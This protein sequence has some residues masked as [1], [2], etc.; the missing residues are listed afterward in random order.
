MELGIK[1]FKV[2][3]SFAIAISGFTNPFL[4]LTLI[5]GI[6]NFNYLYNNIGDALVFATVGFIPPVL[7]YIWLVEKHK[8]KMIHHIALSQEER[9][10]LYLFIAF[11]LSFAFIIFLYQ[12]NI[13]WIDYS[14]LFITFTLT[15]LLI[16]KYI[17]KVSLHSSAATFVII[18]LADKVNMAFTILL[19]ILPFIYWAR[20]KLHKHSW[21]QLMLGTILGMAFGLISW[22]IRIPR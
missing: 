21:T 15:A 6:T 20:I 3:N 13:F 4:L 22:V 8:K 12:K 17:D 14:V 11:S 7:Y 10:K 9:N 18:Y 19:V 5:I 16:N 1:N 2:H